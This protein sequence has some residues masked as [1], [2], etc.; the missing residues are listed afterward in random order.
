MTTPSKVFF[1]TNE[2]TYRDLKKNKP[3]GGRLA[4]YKRGQGVEVWTT[5]NITMLAVVKV[6]FELVGLVLPLQQ[7]L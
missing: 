2:R 6:G 5:T 4:I 1:S 7:S 3:A